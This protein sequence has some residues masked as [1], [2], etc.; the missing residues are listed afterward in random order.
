MIKHYRAKWNIANGL[1]LIIFDSNYLLWL[2]YYCTLCPDRKIH[3]SVSVAFRWAKEG[4]QEWDALADGADACTILQQLQ[5]PLHGRREHESHVWAMVC[6]KQ[7]WP[8][9]CWPCPCLWEK[10]KIFPSYPIWSLKN[11]KTKTYLY[12]RILQYRVSN[13]A[14]NITNGE[15]SPI[16]DQ[17]APVY[18]TVGDGGNIEGLANK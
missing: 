8:C 18:I 15:C 10:C 4:E 6:G 14:Y 9:L 17:S 16:A 12:S 11:C 3:S 5:L 13:I 1:Y 7:S 2:K